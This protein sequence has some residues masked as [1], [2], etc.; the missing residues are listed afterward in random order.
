MGQRGAHERHIL[1]PGKPD[2]GDEFA[3]AAHQAVVF[4]SK[5]PRA[6]PLLRHATP[7]TDARNDPA[8]FILFL[9]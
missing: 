6:Y 9:G 3:A 4:L 5:E 7:S 1:Q 8:E 2:I